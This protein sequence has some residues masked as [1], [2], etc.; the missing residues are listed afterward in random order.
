MYTYIILQP[1]F[2]PSVSAPLPCNLPKKGPPNVINLVSMVVCLGSWENAHLRP[3]KVRSLNM[4]ESN[5][6]KS[7]N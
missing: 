3:P 6:L 2:G 5:Q 7:W 1:H 4:V